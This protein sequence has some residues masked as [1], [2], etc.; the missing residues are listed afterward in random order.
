VPQTKVVKSA[1]VSQAIKIVNRAMV[2]PR[3][4]PKPNILKSKGVFL[5]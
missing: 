3:E 1:R 4:R 5:K 2:Q